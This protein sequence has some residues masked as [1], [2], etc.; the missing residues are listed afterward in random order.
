MAVLEAEVIDKCSKPNKNT[1]A[2]INNLTLQ[3]FD[4]TNE[5]FVPAFPEHF[6]IDTRT[7]RYIPYAAGELEDHEVALSEVL[8]KY[9]IWGVTDPQGLNPPEGAGILTLQYNKQ[10]LATISLAL[11]RGDQSNRR[12]EGLSFIAPDPEDAIK[13]INPNSMGTSE[14]VEFTRLAVTMRQELQPMVKEIGI[15]RIAAYL[16]QGGLVL[17]NME[18]AMRAGSQDLIRYSLGVMRPELAMPIKSVLKT[19]LTKANTG[20]NRDL[21]HVH[22]MISSYPLY[23]LDNPMLTK[24]LASFSGHSEAYWGSTIEAARHGDVESHDVVRSVVNENY[25]EVMTH[26]ADGPNFWYVDNKEMQLDLRRY[27]S[28]H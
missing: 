12:S 26:V 25:D 6:S 21:P 8:R 20:L 16:L 3:A 10:V 18:N 7:G 5:G 22:E 2:V 24:V 28:T 19:S 15:R 9:V 17:T 14:W 23:F 4:V 27:F 1:E 13:V 11:L